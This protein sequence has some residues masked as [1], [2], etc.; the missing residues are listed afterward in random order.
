MQVCCPLPQ[1]DHFG[2]ATGNGNFWHRIAPHIFKQ[3][4][5][6]ITHIHQRD[7]RQVIAGFGSILGAIA[8]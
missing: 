8:G 1:L 6:K 2:K 4:A 3:T 7:I 5:N